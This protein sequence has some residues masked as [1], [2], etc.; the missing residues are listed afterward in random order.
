MCREE[1]DYVE[2]YTAGLIIIITDHTWLVWSV[3]STITI[4]H[5]SVLLLLPS[6]IIQVITFCLV[7]S[8]LWE[9]WLFLLY[10]IWQKQNKTIQP[11]SYTSNPTCFLS[12]PAIIKQTGSYR[13]PDCR[14]DFVNINIPI[15][16]DGV[17]L[18]AGSCK[19]SYPGMWLV[20]WRP[21]NLTCG[22]T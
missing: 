14:H 4:Y 5:L 1:P 21:K 10:K 3:P 11:I 13:Y 22:L 9:N 18:M 7:S 12:L 6:P 2:N 17:T 19:L 20:T 16:H 8:L 15:F